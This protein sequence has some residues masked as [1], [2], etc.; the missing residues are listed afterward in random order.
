MSEAVQAAEFVPDPMSVAILIPRLLYKNWLHV[1]VASEGKLRG[2]LQGSND[3]LKWGAVSEVA[4][5]KLKG[6][7]P[8]MKRLAGEGWGPAAFALTEIGADDRKTAAGLLSS[9]SPSVNLWAALT[10]AKSGDA[11]ARKPLWK[12]LKRK[13]RDFNFDGVARNKAANALLQLERHNVAALCEL[14]EVIGHRSPYEV[15]KLN[16]NGADQAL[17]RTAL[18]HRYHGYR[19]W[20]VMALASTGRGKRVLNPLLDPDSPSDTRGWAVDAVKRLDA[21]ERLAIGRNGYKWIGNGRPA[22]TPR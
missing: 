12:A 17:I 15:A 9:K 2:Y 3:H 21:G 22:R 14:M 8:E 20:S 7:A 10:L 1:A 4:V 6:F 16:T 11:R 18:K 13:D 19:E 5:R